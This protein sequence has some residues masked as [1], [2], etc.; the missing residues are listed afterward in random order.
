MVSFA[1]LPTHYCHCSC[2]C[3][4]TGPDWVHWS[5]A[6]MRYALEQHLPGWDDLVL[7]WVRQANYVKW[8]LQVVEGGGGAG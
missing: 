5:N 4:V 2:Y 8:A 3:Q 1:D 6:D 7:S